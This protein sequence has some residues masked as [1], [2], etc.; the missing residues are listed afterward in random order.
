MA[1]SHLARIKRVAAKRCCVI[2]YDMW[3]HNFYA[4]VEVANRVSKYPRAGGV[5]VTGRD[6][7]K[8]TYALSV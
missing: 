3:L 5:N 2:N 7:R 1:D 4:L 6:E 8:E